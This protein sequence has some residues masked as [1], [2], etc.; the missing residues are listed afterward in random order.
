MAEKGDPSFPQLL[1]DPGVP[2]VGMGVGQQ[3]RMDSRPVDTDLGQQRL[4][5]GRGEPAI[6]QQTPVADLQ[7]ARVSA[8]TARQDMEPDGDGIHWTVG[9][10][11][12]GGNRPRL[13]QLRHGAG[14]PD[15]PVDERFWGSRGGW[16]AGC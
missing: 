6:E 3:E 12:I 2:V 10:F 15:C 9:E 14:Y 13:R 16:S 1:D 11:R 5:P 7:Q 8:G 4:Q